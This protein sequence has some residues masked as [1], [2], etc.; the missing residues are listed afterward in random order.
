MQIV[1]WT[2]GRACVESEIRVIDTI[3]A[4][5]PDILILRDIPR[6]AL[7]RIEDGL[8]TE[9]WG[10]WLSTGSTATGLSSLVLSHWPT[11]RRRR[12]RASVAR[13]HVIRF[14]IEAPQL[15]IMA[16]SMPRGASASVFR[17]ALWEDVFRVSEEAS[18]PTLVIGTFDRTLS[19]TRPSLDGLHDLCTSP[20]DSSEEITFRSRSGSAARVD[21]AFGTPSVR[22]ARL[23]CEYDHLVR[24]QLISDHSLVRVDLDEERIDT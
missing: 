18:A 6:E 9:S 15:E 16:V 4:Y 11:T 22:A 23:R 3:R 10:H 7:R 24:E 14:S 21:L 13:G 17:R 2:L 5:D 8:S 1:S 20:N 12:T 19:R